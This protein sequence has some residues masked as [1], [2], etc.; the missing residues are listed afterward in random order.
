[1]AAGSFGP[2]IIF[3][4]QPDSEKASGYQDLTYLGRNQ[5]TLTVNFLVETILKQKSS[6]H[7]WFGPYLNS[8]KIALEFSNQLKAAKHSHGATSEHS[9]YDRIFGA[10]T[11]P[12]ELV[13]K[14]VVKHKNG[15]EYLAMIKV[16]LDNLKKQLKKMKPNSYIVVFGHPRIISSF[17]TLMTLEN[18]DSEL[19]ALG[20]MYKLADASISV[21]GY[22]EELWEIYQT[23]SVAHLES[24][25]I[26]GAHS[27]FGHI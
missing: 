5:S 13:E 1:M 6:V 20:D 16:L 11:I 2:Q 22:V 8:R 3:V 9:L 17:L 15:K 26:S 23:G 25:A 14:G 19:V 12:K 21:V 27:P 4:N 7:L 10:T 24:T 18:A